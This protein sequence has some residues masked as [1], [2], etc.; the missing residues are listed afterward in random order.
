MQ[1]E[2]SFFRSV[3][4]QASVYTGEIACHLMGDPLTHSNLHAYL[5]IIHEYGL[6]AVLTT[7]G[8]FLK[9]QTYDT[10]FH[11]CVKQINISLNSYNK[12]DT[13]VGLE[14]YMGPVLDLCKEKLE[15]G[16]ACFINLR[17]WNLDEIM[18]ERHF[19][20]TLFSS[21]QNIFGIGLSVEEIYHQRP[22][23]I[24]LAEKILLHFDTYFEWPSL[25]NPFYGD[26]SCQGLQSH[27]G[28]LAD[29]R[30]VPCCLDSE[31]II[32][33]GNL[34]EKSLDEIL[35]SKRVKNIRQGFR[36]GKAVEELCQKCSYKERFNRE[37]K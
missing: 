16:A 15:R 11:P 30:V 10:L 29:G 23:S 28:I 2:L 22:H 36:E 35:Q 13:A 34:H 20:E 3:V 27:I 9:K 6:R 1:M 21:L 33:L 37:K 4:R 17:V 32:T 25:S 31:G 26:G 8:F 5:D 7:S 24:R 19:N 14:Q 18:S 12:N